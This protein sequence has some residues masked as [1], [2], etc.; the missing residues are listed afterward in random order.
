[1][2]WKRRVRPVSEPAAPARVIPRL[3]RNTVSVPAQ[4]VPLYEYLEHR[5]ATMVVLT[6][7]QM[8]ALL[9]TS[10]PAPARTEP[11]WWTGAS[12]TT[13]HSSAWTHAGRTAV[14]NL[15][16]KTVTFERRN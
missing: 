9:G 15:L 3:Q 12:D 7:D 10:L 2:L 14:P 6:F 8:E 1:M 4:Y 11:Q 13:S 5:Y 16:A